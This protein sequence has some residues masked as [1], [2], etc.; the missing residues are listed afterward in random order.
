[1]L[2]KH[3]YILNPDLT[4]D[5]MFG[6]CSAI[7]GSFGTFVDAAFDSTGDVYVVD[8]ECNIGIQ[9][10]TPDGQYLRKFGSEGSGQG[11][12]GSPI[13]IAIDDQDIVYV[14]ECFDV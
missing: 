9:I 11:E 10:F 4:F 1:M 8:K 5:H 6:G 3:V 12:L 14:T 13:G 7:P 2:T